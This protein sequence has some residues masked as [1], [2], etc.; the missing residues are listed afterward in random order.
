MQASNVLTLFLS[1]IIDDEIFKEI[2]SLKDGK[3][4]GID[5]IT[6]KILKSI[7]HVIVPIL[8]HIFNLVLTSGIYPDALKVAKV[9][10]IFK[11]GDR[12]QPENYR[13]IS[14]L[15]CINK[16]LER[17]IEK[18]LRLF[19]E[20]NSTLYDFQFGFRKCHDTSHAL[21]ETVNCIRTYLDN[22]HNVLGLYLDL[23][24]AFDTVDHKIVL[25]KL[26]S[27]SICGNAYNVLA[28]YLDNRKQ[29][30]WCSIKFFRCSYWCSPGVCSRTL[31]IFN[32]CQ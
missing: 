30:K 23:R 16:L 29:C 21:L 4:P 24:K 28:S 25:H 27:Y 5:G 10:P 14:L 7:S 31:A 6:P 20:N 8:S 32:L 1:P 26:S 19:M 15:S 11:K 22:G 2:F 9:I 18:R 13:P 3:S 17:S 12:N